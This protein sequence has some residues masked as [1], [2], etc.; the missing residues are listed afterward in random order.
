[1]EAQPCWREGTALQANIKKEGAKKKKKNK[2]TGSGKIKFSQ[3]AKVVPQ[4][5]LLDGPT[6]K[7]PI[8]QRRECKSPKRRPRGWGKERQRTDE[9]SLARERVHIPTR[10]GR[11]ECKRR[12]DGYGDDM[13]EMIMEREHPQN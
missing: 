4:K 12:C 10:K 1:M 3:W 11:S 9:L 13:D 2:K 8:H 5:G 7:K 6:K